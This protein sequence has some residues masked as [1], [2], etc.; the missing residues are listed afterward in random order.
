M[1][2]EKIKPP[3]HANYDCLQARIKSFEKYDWSPQIEQTPHQLAEAGF[4]YTGYGDATIC[5][6]CHC[7][8][9]KWLKNDNPFT[10]HAKHSP[11]CHY[12]KVVKGE[13]FINQV[14]TRM[15][16]QPACFAE[17][18]ELL[19][20]P[21]KPKAPEIPKEILEGKECII[22]TTEER[23]VAFQPCG[24]LSTCINCSFKISTCCICRLE[25]KSRIRI[26][27]A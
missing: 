4:F 3:V 8:L 16:S 24:H 14:R 18:R 6:Y 11:T 2:P 25:I 19:Q 12:L 17:I 13:A 15:A 27:Q 9:K 7:G 20:R 22:C 5:F 21:R 1:N 10:E 26:I 23:E